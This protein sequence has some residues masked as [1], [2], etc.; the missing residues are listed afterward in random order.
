M[1]TTAD[2]TEAHNPQSYAGATDPGKLPMDVEDPA[3]LAVPSK[4]LC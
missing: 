1:G 4:D 2:M 3:I